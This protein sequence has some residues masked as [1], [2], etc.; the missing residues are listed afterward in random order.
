V[1]V[2][3]VVRMVGIVVIALLLVAGMWAV[4]ETNWM[5]R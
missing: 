2:E 4:R 5:Q 1:N 3:L